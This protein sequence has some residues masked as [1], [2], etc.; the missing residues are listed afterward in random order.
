[1]EK[2]LENTKLSQEK[3][4]K[5]YDNL[6][7]KFQDV[8][9]KWVSGGP[10]VP[11]KSPDT[12]PDLDLIYRSAIPSGST[13]VKSL[14]DKFDRGDNRTNEDDEVL[15]HVITEQKKEIENLRSQVVS[16]DKRITALEEMLRAYNINNGG[17]GSIGETILAK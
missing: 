11:I 2:N 8:H 17:S 12:E 3:Q 16:K 13:P 10:T 1:M 9:R 7:T 14:T 5:T 15:R 4:K 6:G